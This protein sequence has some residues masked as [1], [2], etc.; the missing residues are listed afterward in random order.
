[1]KSTKE[2]DEY[3]KNL[4][5][6][7]FGKYLTGDYRTSYATLSDY[8]NAYIGSHGLT[9][10]DI[11]RGSLLSSDYAYQ[12]LNG[13]KKSPSRERLIPLCLSMKMSAEDTNR[14]LK[15][16]CA[17]ELYSKIPRDAAIIVCINNCVFDVMRVNEYLVSQ[18]FEPFAGTL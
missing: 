12:I 14:A 15:L 8:L 11:I 5:P 6:D 3:L 16:A 2:T 18:G 10:P 1:M 17:G 9:V 7:E 13:R 4:S